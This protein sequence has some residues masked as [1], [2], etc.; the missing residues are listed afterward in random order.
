MPARHSIN[1]DRERGIRIF[2]VLAGFGN[3]ASVKLIGSGDMNRPIVLA[4]YLVP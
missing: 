2:N 1:N 4:M 3:R